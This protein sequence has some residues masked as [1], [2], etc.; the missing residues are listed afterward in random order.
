MK[1]PDHSYLTGSVSNPLLEPSMERFYGVLLFVDISG[2]TLLS[3]KLT[4]DELRYHIN[5]YFDRILRIVE[6]YGGQ[7][8][9]FAGDALYILWQVE[10]PSKETDSEGKIYPVLI[11]SGLMNTFK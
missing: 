8:V 9:K 11:L 6:L 1:E 2:F 4:I 7:T 5:D 3:T 10:L